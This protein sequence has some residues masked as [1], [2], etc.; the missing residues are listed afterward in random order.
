M[1]EL[2]AVLCAGTASGSSV[3]ER[4]DA[5]AACR[6]L[7]AA[8][9]TAPGQPLSLF[10]ASAHHAPYVPSA[11]IGD[12]FLG[13]EVGEGHYAEAMQSDGRAKG[14]TVT[15]ELCDPSEVPPLAVPSSW[16]TPV[17][18]SLPSTAE[19]IATLLRLA[20]SMPAEQLLT[21]VN[22][23]LPSF[24]EAKAHA[25]S[26]GALSS[27]RTSRP[28]ASSIGRDSAATIYSVDERPSVERRA[29]EAS[30]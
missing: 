18:Q 15:A 14:H 23:Y 11:S 12:V 7:L 2:L 4:A 24:L 21:L 25:V 19:S 6:I 29:G 1:E 20:Q 9:E 28:D 3:A 16:A 10:T 26:S 5:A 13:E 17:P 8:L 27:P 30:P 22:A